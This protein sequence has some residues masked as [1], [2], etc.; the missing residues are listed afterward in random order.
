MFVVFPFHAPI[1]GP[2]GKKRVLT[3]ARDV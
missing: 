2:L 1:F 3:G